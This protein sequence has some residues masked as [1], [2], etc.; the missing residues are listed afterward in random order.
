MPS[1]LRLALQLG[2]LRPVVRLRPRLD[3]ALANRLRRIRDDERHVELDDVAEAMARRAGA[4]RVVEREQPR[5]RIFVGDVAAAALETLAELMQRRRAGVS[6]TAS[7]RANAAP[8]PSRY[9]VS[10]ESASLARASPSIWMRSTTTWMAARPASAA[11]ST[12]SRPTVWPSTSSRR[13]PRL[14]RLWIV[15]RSARGRGRAGGPVAVALGRLSLAGCHPLRGPRPA[16]DPAPRPPASRTRPAAASPPAG[17]P[18][19]APR[20]RRFRA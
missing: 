15:S 1:R 11:R 19:A 17:R 18:G 8:P 12:S 7:C 14:D 3:R 2:Q 13:N 5:L 10:I 16:A 9:A 20:R 4:E 6:S